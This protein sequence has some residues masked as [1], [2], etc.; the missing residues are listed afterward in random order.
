MKIKLQSLFAITIFLFSSSTLFADVSVDKGKAIFTTRC[1]SCHNVNA[2]LVGPALA[3]VDKRR[4]FD[5]I[6]NFV[7]SPKAAIEKNDT[8]AVALYNQFDQI[9][10]PDHSDLSANDIKS[11][12]DYIKSETK[13][14]PAVTAPFAKPGKLVPDYHPLS[15]QKNYGFFI[16]FLV[17]VLVLVLLLLFAVNMKDIERKTVKR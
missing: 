2:K 8:A 4:T 15:V 14:T 10:M 9:V 17:S 11:V 12:L 3:N 5:W 13:A 16:S 7:H 1:T 6:V